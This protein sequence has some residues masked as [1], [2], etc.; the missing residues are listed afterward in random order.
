MVKKYLET[1]VGILMLLKF[2]ALKLENYILLVEL[3]SEIKKNPKYFWE[4]F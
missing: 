1:G 3:I 2:K 4:A